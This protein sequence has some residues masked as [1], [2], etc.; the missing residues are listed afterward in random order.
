MTEFESV[1][2]HFLMKPAVVCHPLSKIGVA[3]YVCFIYSMV[4][5]ISS[6]KGGPNFWIFSGEPKRWGIFK[7][8]NQHRKKPM[9]SIKAC[10]LF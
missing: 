7:G 1:L 6:V 2:K 3:T 10:L 5:C 9:I 8:E 4:H